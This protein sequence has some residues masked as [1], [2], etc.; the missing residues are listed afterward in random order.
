VSEV[1]VIEFCK[2]ELANRRF[3]RTAYASSAREAHKRGNTIAGA[4][5]L[6][7]EFMCYALDKWRPD[8]TGFS[9]WKTLPAFPAAAALLLVHDLRPEHALYIAREIFGDEAMDGTNEYW[10]TR[11]K[12]LRDELAFDIHVETD[13]LIKEMDACE[14]SMRRILDSLMG[15]APLQQQVNIFVIDL[16]LALWDGCDRVNLRRGSQ[17]QELPLKTSRF[18][19]RHMKWE[20]QPAASPLLDL[21]VSVALK[22]LG[23]LG[24][25]KPK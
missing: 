4:V 10:Q 15:K 7:L 19:G 11:V 21:K 6:I 3:P 18:S 9:A 5:F 24:E 1:S 13:H 8:N 12:A 22:V 17:A 23:A 2:H 16:V 25:E 20:V 14:P